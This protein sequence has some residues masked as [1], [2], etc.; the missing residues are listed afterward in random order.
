MENVIKL[1]ISFCLGEAIEYRYYM[2]MIFNNDVDIKRFQN[3]KGKLTTLKNLHVVEVAH[4]G[5]V[6]LQPTS[7]Y[8]VT[9]RTV[10][11]DNMGQFTNYV[12]YF[13]CYFQPLFPVLYL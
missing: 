9:Y 2:Q 1:K 11:L 13:F 4:V 3:K 8:Y 12:I 6:R 10:H 7:N 5:C